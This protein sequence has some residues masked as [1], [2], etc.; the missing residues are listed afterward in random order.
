[1]SVTSTLEFLDHAIKD[2]FPGDEVVDQITRN[3]MLYQ[4]LK[5]AGNDMGSRVRVTQDNVHRKIA[6]PIHL[7]QTGGFGRTTASGDMPSYS[8]D[9]GGEKFLLS[10]P[11]FWMKA[12]TTYEMLR[13]ASTRIIGDNM[14][15][16]LEDT[17]K[18]LMSMMSS[19]FL[20]DGYATITNVTGIAVLTGSDYNVPVT[21]TATVSIGQWIEI[22]DGTQTQVANNVLVAG[23]STQFGAGTIKLTTATDLVAA[24][25]TSSHTINPENTSLQTVQPHGLTE[26]VNDTGT[27]PTANENG[28]NRALPQYVDW[29]SY[30]IDATAEGWANFTAYQL[31]ERVIRQQ[32]YNAI[33]LNAPMPDG[34]VVRKPAKIMYGD[35]DVFALMAEDAREQ[36]R[37]GR[38]RVPDLGFE[39]DAMHGIPM[40]GDPYV[41]NRTYFLDLSQF[42]FME[43]P[44]EFF[45]GTTGMWLSI[46]RTD[47]LEA[48]GAISAQIHS[49]TLKGHA[50]TKNIDTTGVNPDAAAV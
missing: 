30:V 20:T 29:R 48:K 10:V 36:V 8:G 31:A 15:D 32:A 1:M 3:S 9:P 46:A 42:W 13:S 37:Y 19:A 44:F 11:M 43:D 12:E 34:K 47:R 18:G 26:I 33:T 21:D 49:E 6:F 41:H 35:P 14:I 50:L 27:Y 17:K 16:Q 7:K 40:I 39:V 45:D 23:K 4:V 28:L 38:M 24:K 22:L 2:L 25:L 5:G